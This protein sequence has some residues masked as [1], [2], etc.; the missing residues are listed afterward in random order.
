[1]TSCL[2]MVSYYYQPFILKHIIILRIARKCKNVNIKKLNIKVSKLQHIKLSKNIKV[3][4][5]K[6]T[7]DSPRFGLGASR[8]QVGHSTTELR[9]R[10]QDKMYPVFYFM[11]AVL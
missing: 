4:N 7:M 8:V 6:I 9:A 11:N 1:M 3:T 10:W 2:C 5:Y